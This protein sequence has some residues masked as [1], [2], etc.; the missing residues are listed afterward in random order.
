MSER[1]ENV[2][3]EEA[4]DF[5]E[6]NR[7]ELACVS[8]L[9]GGSSPTALGGRYSLVRVPSDNVESFV[10][11]LCGS[12]TA[13]IFAGVFKPGEFDDGR[14]ILRRIVGERSY[15]IR[16][17][18]YR[19]N[20]I[21]ELARVLGGSVDVRNPEVLVVA[22]EIPAG[23]LVGAVTAPTA[24]RLL[25]SEPAK[26]WPY[27]HPGVLAPY[28]SGILCNLTLCPARGLLYDPF[29][30]A[31]STLVAGCRLGL[32]VVGGE[33]SKKQV[34]G[35]RRN[36][37]HFCDGVEGILRADAVHP[38]LRPDTANAAVFD[39][40]YGRV[41]SLFGRSL[42]GLLRAC[43]LVTK[44]VLHSGGR[45]VF[46]APSSIDLAQIVSEVGLKMVYQHEIRV[47][48][49]LTRVISVTEKGG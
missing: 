2:F 31:G 3:A 12:H 7:F 1:W 42:T 44:A 27:F 38:Y 21:K 19:A 37:N 24:R 22:N 11:R 8:R 10:K 43:L 13:G 40:P 5:P 48:H 29:C 15:V 39:P 35:A 28:F 25:S 30:G 4:L 9:F 26:R 6:L 33:L 32:R 20:Y 14:D 41:S 45:A 18:P 49:S 46:L 34:Y 36:V 17:K 16:T 23:V 47:H